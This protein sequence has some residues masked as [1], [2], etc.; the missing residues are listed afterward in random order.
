[1]ENECQS[2]KEE[3]TLRT[4]RL[5]VSLHEY[6]IENNILTEQKEEI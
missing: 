4:D 2:K 3:E 1:M 5:Q 6:I